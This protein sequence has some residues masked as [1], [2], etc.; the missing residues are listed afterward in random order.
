MDSPLA[1][2]VSAFPARLQSDAAAV[3]RGLDGFASNECV[4]LIVEGETVRVP[5]R[6]YFEPSLVRPLGSARATILDCLLSRNHNGFVRQ[7]A[8]GRLI[9]V[10]APWSTPFVLHL[11]GEYVI[12]ILDLIDARIGEIDPRVTG[13]FLRANPGFHRLL[14]QRVA[15]YWNAYHRDVPRDGYVGFRLMGRLDAM[16]ASAT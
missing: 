9:G 13:D 4:S 10:N 2:A 11:V 5:A 3:V 12:E 1:T 7:E 14:G 6:T 16:A 8:A 15:S